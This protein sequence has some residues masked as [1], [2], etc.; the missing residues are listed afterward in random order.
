MLHLFVTNTTECEPLLFFHVRE[1]CMGHYWFYPLYSIIF[2]S[3]TLSARGNEPLLC[4]VKWLMPLQLSHDTHRLLFADLCLQ[5][6]APILW[7]LFQS[8]IKTHY[9][10]YYL[11]ELLQMCSSVCALYTLTIPRPCYS[12]FV[13]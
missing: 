10:M 8:A 4:A 13:I 2:H 12:R 9:S 3:I 7:N 6:C 11:C 1:A 5:N